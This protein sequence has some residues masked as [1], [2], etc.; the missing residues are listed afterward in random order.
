MTEAIAEPIADSRLW[1][2]GASG[3]DQVQKYAQTLRT[4]DVQEAE[5]GTGRS[6]EGSPIAKQF[7]FVGKV[8]LQSGLGPTMG[9]P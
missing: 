9:F 6:G 7:G 5:V 2:R 1:S 3:I 4:I 8:N